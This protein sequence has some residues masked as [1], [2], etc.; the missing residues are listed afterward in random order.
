MSKKNLPVLIITVLV[1]SALSFFGGMQ[2]QKSQRQSFQTGFGRSLNRQ[3]GAGVRPVSGE[4]TNV[5]KGL[6]TIKTQ[7]GSNRIIIFSDS[8]KI[9][10]TSDGSASDLKKGE[11]VTG[12][13]KEGSDGTITA[14]TLMIGEKML[15]R[16]PREDATEENQK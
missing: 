16:P 13:G 6:L 1:F 8:T 11:Q 14:Q 9:N 3:N 2:Y 4:I 7:D 12:F 15:Q 5:E 10:K